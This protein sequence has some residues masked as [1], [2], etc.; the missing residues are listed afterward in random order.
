MLLVRVV[1]LG[2]RSLSN[3]LLC[4]RMICPSPC[5]SFCT[6]MI[7]SCLCSSFCPSM[8][9]FLLCS[10]LGGLSFLNCFLG[11]CPIIMQLLAAGSL[12]LLGKVVPFTSSFSLGCWPP[13]RPISPP[14]CLP[15]RHSL[16]VG[17]FFGLSVMIAILFCVMGMAEAQSTLYGVHHRSQAQ[18]CTID[19]RC[20]CHQ[21]CD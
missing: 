17:L 7:C 3:W 16:S 14:S 1:S 8:I 20:C 9:C 15:V 18:L 11:R 5:T 4:T 12:P 2:I 19:G 6:W 10:C 13:C 21:A